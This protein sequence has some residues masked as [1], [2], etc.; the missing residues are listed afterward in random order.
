MLQGSLVYRLHRKGHKIVDMGAHQRGSHTFRLR[1]R[2]R[3]RTADPRRSTAGI[4]PLR[5]R[6]D[7]SILHLHLLAGL[8]TRTSCG[9]VAKVPTDSNNNSSTHRHHKCSQMKTTL[10][11]PVVASR[12]RSRLRPLVLLLHLSLP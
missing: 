12:S 11:R 3:T 2:P 5:L 4:R 8:C 1:R 6:L 10:F 7:S 9:N